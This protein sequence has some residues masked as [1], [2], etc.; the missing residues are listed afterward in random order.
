MTISGK[1]CE[2][3][4]VKRSGIY[5]CSEWT[6]LCLHS[7]QEDVGVH[8]GNVYLGKRKRFEY[9]VT[10][11]HG[12]VLSGPGPYTG[13]SWRTGTKIHSC[14]RDYTSLLEIIP[15]LLVTYG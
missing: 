9:G 1:G 10:K 3:G 2:S 13:G 12:P 5:R 4:E 8:H 15:L 6:P 14:L 11:T 7:L